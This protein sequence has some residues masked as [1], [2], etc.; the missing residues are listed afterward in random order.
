MKRHLYKHEKRPT[1]MSQETYI[2][3]KKETYIHMKR[4]LYKHEKR[5]TFMSQETYIYIKKETYIHMKRHLYTHEKRPIFMSQETYIYIKKTYTGSAIFRRQ[6][7]TPP[8]HPP[9]YIYTCK[10]TYVYVKR[11]LHIHIYVKLRQTYIPK[12]TYIYTIQKDSAKLCSPTLHRSIIHNKRP[13]Y[14]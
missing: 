10:K 12:E 14:I 6:I 5:P 2:Y 8:P 13:M 1:F 11:G 7:Q 9:Q 4:H 3:I